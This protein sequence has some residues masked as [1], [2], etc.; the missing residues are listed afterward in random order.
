VSVAAPPRRLP[1]APVSIDFKRAAPTLIAGV[2]A[3]VYV[4]VSPPSFDLAA[5]LLRAKLFRSD[6]F[7][8]WNN[9]W[10]GGHHTLGYSV[11]FPPISALLSPQLAAGIAATGTAAL[12]EPLA[13]RH[14]GPDSWLGSAWFG[15]ATATNLF[16]G[17]LAF[18]F[19]L[20]P[21]VGTM[22][23]LQRKRPLLACTLA[24][25]TALASP[26]AALFAALGGAAVAIGAYIP[27]RDLRATAPGIG[28]IVAALLP[29]AA[30]SVAFPE[31]GSE[32]FTLATLGPVAVVAVVTLAVLPRTEWSLRAGVA[33]YV[34][35][36]IVAYVVPTPVGSNAARLGDMIAGPLAALIWWRRRAAFVVAT[37]LPLLY[38]QWQAPIRDVYITANDP[39]VSASYYQ[40]LLT[41]LSAQQGPPFRVEIPFTKFH[42]E[43]YDVAP[44]FPLARG[45]ERQLDIKYNHLFYGGAL[46]PAT[47]EQWLHS[48]AVRFVAASDAR[49]DYSAKRETALIDRGLPYLHLV[50][51]TRHW[52]VYA[53]SDPRPI[54]QGPATLTSLGPSSLT[55]NARRA[56]TILVRVRFTPYWSIETGSGCVE[57]DGDFTALRLRRPGTVRLSTSF[58]L[59][60]I[61]AKSARCN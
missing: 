49:L 59:D 7:G 41:F 28:V 31:G 17:R 45:W 2:L 26:V 8:L 18:A 20:L 38:L 43:A 14:F 19:G 15:A 25:I 50:L 46:T 12:F 58:A 54:V 35:G 16:T 22:L 1:R 44:Q 33:I 48:M 42:W 27:D 47:Y 5:H 39:S 37:A 61:R 9:W 56:A 55:L 6:G 32:P 30:L 53:V 10:Y 21:A 60:R 3:T 23:A 11:L 57:P 29:V 52:R 34:V 51:R 36:C 4:I 24:L 40:P 13:R